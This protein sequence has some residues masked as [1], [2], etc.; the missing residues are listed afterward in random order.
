M[1]PRGLRGL[2]TIDRVRVAIAALSVIA[3][4]A[5]VIALGGKDW[6]SKPTNL[7]GD[8]LGQQSGESLPDYLVR[9]RTSL[10]AASGTEF[11]LVTFSRPL[12]SQ[13]AGALL[14]DENL[15]RVNAAIP[16]ASV[17]VALPEPTAGKS[18]AEV[19]AQQLALAHAEDLLGGVVV[20]SDADSL[21]ALASHEGVLAVESLPEDAAW[22]RIGVRP[23]ELG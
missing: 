2:D 11:A 10:E 15:R 7:N 23:V 8:T 17:P 12:S 19:L 13:E 21:R 18:R 20:Y 16:E 1:S 9:A 3:L 6:V 14:D 5:V 4:V 22:G